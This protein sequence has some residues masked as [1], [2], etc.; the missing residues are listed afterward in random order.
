MALHAD[1]PAEVP[2]ALADRLRRLVTMHLDLDPARLRAGAL[3]SEDLGVDS[4]AAIEL[5]MA[6][7]DEFDISLPD[8]VLNDVRSY[9]DLV[10]VVRSRVGTAA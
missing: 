6:I 10:D 2:G 9:G 1:R 4:L 8:E 3:L 7:E 5:G